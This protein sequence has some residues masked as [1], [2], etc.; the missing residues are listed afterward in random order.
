MDEQPAILL[1]DDVIYTGRT[2]RSAI[3]E[4]VD[5]GR[6]RCIRLG[7]LV[8]R[9]HR[10]YP[11]QPDVAAMKIETTRDQVVKVMVSEFD[12]R[13]GVILGERGQE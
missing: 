6:P 1:I 9:G 12:E 11:L 8:D 10:E 5:F 4:L 3:D 13:D 7:V 2:A